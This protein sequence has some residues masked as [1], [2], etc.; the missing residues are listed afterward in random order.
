MRASCDM[1]A[2]VPACV[3]AGKTRAAEPLPGLR[4]CAVCGRA[5]GPLR[6]EQPGSVADL[7]LILGGK[8]LDNAD[9]LEGA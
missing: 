1:P 4:R 2:R 9:M 6:A 7:K 3:Y 5:E 8:F